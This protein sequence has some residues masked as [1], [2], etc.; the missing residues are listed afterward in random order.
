MQTIHN[1][2]A[3]VVT[4]STTWQLIP[5]QMHMSLSRQT[6]SSMQNFGLKIPFWWNLET[7]LKICA[8][9]L[10]SQKNVTSCPHPRTF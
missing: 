8:P 6:A 10:L 9:T 1:E 2:S 5:T 7:K 3:T 4:C